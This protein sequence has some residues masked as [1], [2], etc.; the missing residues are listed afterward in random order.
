M[1]R[2]FQYDRKPK[3]ILDM[4]GERAVLNLM[5]ASLIRASETWKRIVITDF[6]LRQLQQLREHLNEG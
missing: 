6:E 5:Y 1:G 3:I 4:Y 2:S